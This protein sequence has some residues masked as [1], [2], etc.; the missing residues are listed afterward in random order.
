MGLRQNLNLSSPGYVQEQRENSLA[1]RLPNIPKQSTEDIFNLGST[2]T[3]TLKSDIADRAAKVKALENQR[4]MA[5]I[6]TALTSVTNVMA[7]ESQLEAI[8]GA[9]ATN[10]YSLNYQKSLIMAAGKQAALDRQMEGELNADKAALALAAQG[11]DINSAGANKVLASY[12][13]IALENAVREEASMYA[14][15]AGVEMQIANE[16]YNVRVAENQNQ[17]ALYQGILNTGMALAG[18]YAGG[19][20]SAAGTGVNSATPSSTFDARAM[21]TLNRYGSFGD[22]NF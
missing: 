1:V 17:M 10:V 14:E 13:A 7:S 9:S 5:L 4:T 21:E 18:S 19:S 20:S 8:S 6:N 15:I 12:R 16:R 3:D 11:Q 2:E 22:F